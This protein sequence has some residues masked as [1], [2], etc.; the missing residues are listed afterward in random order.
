MFRRSASRF[1]AGTFLV[2][3]VAGGGLVLSETPAFATNGSLTGVTWTVSNNTANVV[4]EGN[5]ATYTW[6]F[7]TAT[8]L[9][10]TSITF[11]VPT[12]T[13]GASLTVPGLYGLGVDTAT[14][15]LSGG[16][17]T[18]TLSGNAPIAAGTSVEVAIAGFTNGTVTGSQ[19]TTVTTSDGTNTDSGTASATFANNTTS[20]TVIVPESLTFTNNKSSITLTPVPGI[21]AVESSP[22]TLTVSTNARNGYTLSACATTLSD[23]HSN[24]ISQQATAVASLSGSAFGAK[25]SVS[26]GSAAVQAP[27][28]ASTYIGY[29]ATCSATPILGG[30]P[31]SPVV[32]DAGPTTLDTLTITN[33]VSISAIQAADTYTATINY[34]LTPSY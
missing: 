30:A 18:L 26:G 12:G 19:L 34:L 2:A 13:T 11:T 21:P 22:A 6:A 8:T 25:A 29:A 28:T 17:V 16:T 5:S 4:A 32:T 33:A 14:A 23:G 27:W 3:A 15:S 24:T 10:L 31:S 20:V 1:L 7:T 9:N